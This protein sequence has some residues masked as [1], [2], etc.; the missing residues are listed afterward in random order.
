[1]QRLKDQVQQERELKDKTASDQLWFPRTQLSYQVQRKHCYNHVEADSR[2]EAKLPISSRQTFINFMKD[3]QA[4]DYR[5]KA[6]I[7]S[8]LQDKENQTMQ[9]VTFTPTIDKRSQ[10]L[11]SKRDDWKIECRLL[12]QGVQYKNRLKELQNS[13]K[14]PFKPCIYD[15]NRSRCNSTWR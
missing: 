3:H 4:W 13:Q 15:K 11:A 7:E 2:E 5:R 8:Q 9:D 6:K 1:M 14:L 12:N 10:R